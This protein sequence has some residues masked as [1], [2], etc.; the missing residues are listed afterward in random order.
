ML[1]TLQLYVVCCAVL[2]RFLLPPLN[3]TSDSCLTFAYNMYGF[4]MGTLRVYMTAADG[5]RTSLWQSRSGDQ[6]P[7]WLTAN[8]TLVAPLYPNLQVNLCESFLRRIF[9]RFYD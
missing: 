3:T 6:G 9:K 7:H 1:L 5:T 2:R 8:V 4:H